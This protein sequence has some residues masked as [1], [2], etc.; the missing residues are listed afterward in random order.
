MTDRKYLDAAAKLTKL[1]RDRQLTHRTP[2]TEIAHN[3]CLNRASVAKYLDR[4]VD[5]PLTVF[6]AT[7]DMTG[8]DPVATLA[9]VCEE[10]GITPKETA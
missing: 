5:M 8:G 4:S 3:T 10:Y 6:I 9:H 1:T 2:R 7:Q